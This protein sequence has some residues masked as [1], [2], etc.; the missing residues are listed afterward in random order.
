MV[1]HDGASFGAGRVS[2]IH[3]DAHADTGNI[4]FGSLIG[5]GQ[6]MRRL[7][8]SGVRLMACGLRTA[9]ARCVIA[10]WP[11]SSQVEP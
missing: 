3:F 7:I 4:E 11:R 10:I 6:P 9:W 2:M 1:I 5:H 8:E